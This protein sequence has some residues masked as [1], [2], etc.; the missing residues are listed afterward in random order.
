MGGRGTKFVCNQW[1]HDSAP[2]LDGEESDEEAAVLEAAAKEAVA[3]QEQGDEAD[4][5]KVD[6]WLKNPGKKALDVY[7]Y[8]PQTGEEVKVNTMEPR[9]GARLNTFHSHVFVIK[10]GSKNVFQHTVDGKN[11]KRQEQK[12]HHEL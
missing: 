2:G 7:W 11:G 4:D 3:S 1:I 12:I 8:N 10:D 9:G 5:G 6:L